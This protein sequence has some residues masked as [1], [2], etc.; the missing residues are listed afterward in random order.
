MR[1]AIAASAIVAA[2]ASA[3]VPTACGLDFSAGIATSYD[4]NILGYSERDLFAFQYRLNPPRFALKTTDDV[5]LAPYVEIAWE[6]D[7]IRSNSLLAR[8]TANRY[9][10]NT[11]RD[12]YESFLQWRMWPRR[13]LRLTISGSYLPSYYMRRYADDE[14]VV[15]YPQLPRYRDA[16]YR[17]TGG[18]ASIEWRPRGS[19]RGQLGYEYD[20]R[21]FL[22]AFAERDENRH[23]MKLTIRAPRIRQFEGRVRVTYGRALA[24]AQDGD[25]ADGPADDPDISTR[26]LAAGFTLEWVSRRRD[27]SIALRQTVDYE[28]R[29]YTTNDI[30]DTRR[31]GRSIH[32]TGVEWELLYGFSRHWQAGASYGIDLQRLTGPVSDL[33]AFTDASSYNRHQ[34]SVSLGW[35]SRR[36]R[37]E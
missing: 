13:R 28:A 12:N 6:P 27:P 33:A 8:L 5:V 2:L 20:R 32:E 22:R 1:P 23:A 10:T 9:A 3:G 17:Q 30:S 34:V 25:E 18:S 24:R 19:W 16:R 21:D 26:S 37:S 36:K 31:F 14:V 15:P 4:D 35:T 11:I 29:R 7:S